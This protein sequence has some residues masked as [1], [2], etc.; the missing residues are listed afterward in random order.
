M[1]DKPLIPYIRQSRS[2]ER[3]I[4]LDEQRHTIERW[5][6]GAG[7]LL[8]EAVVEQGV[9][10]SK[11]WRERALGAVI[12]QIE[13]GEAGGICVAFQDR[14]SREN[15]LATSEV[16]EALDKA[17]ARLVAAGEGLDTATGDQEL[18]FTIKA[19]IAR[20]QWKRYKANWKAASDQAVVRGKYQGVT[21]VGFNRNGDGTL[22][23]NADAPAVR[24]V[25][26]QRASGRS[27]NHLA[28]DFEAAGVE[29]VSYR[30]AREN[31]EEARKKEDAKKIERFEAT[32]AAGPRWHINSVRSLIGNPIYK[33]SLQNGI[34]HHFPKYA[35]VTPSEWQRAQ[36][37]R[38]DPGARR[39]HGKWAVLGGMVFC[40]GCGGR[41]TP[42]RTTRNGKTYSY[43]KCP[44]R[45]CSEKAYAPA[46]EL[47]ALVVES[48]LATFEQIVAS[49]AV[50]MGHD[51]DVEKQ[52]ALEQEIDDAKARRRAA[53]L[54]LDP[55]DAEDVAVL[56]SLTEAVEVAKAALTD[57]VGSARTTV[58][59]EQW[60][61]SWDAWSIE[62]RRE[63]L[64]HIL[65]RVVVSKTGSRWVEGT[66]T[67][68]MLTGTGKVEPSKAL[69]DRVQVEYRY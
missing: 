45:T 63:A 37:D 65:D 53:A 6:K 21:P 57:E 60:R 25:F 58:T 49:G 11:P 55:N 13:A 51:T 9:S 64:A 2:K 41:M 33:G 28:S 26:I 34:E 42:N 38:E 59:P 23:Q 16:W 1:T 7:V 52:T 4:S 54:A 66:T 24:Q 19:A 39:D 31:I 56:E 43:Y 44:N 48:A 20:D 12:A 40:A 15:G 50:R 35:I 67:D 47:E 69:G 17:G 22:R 10:G 36:P 30:H 18:L 14:L 61:D 46:E 5:A 27:W 62:E 68:E 3:T 29:P 8:T 32:L